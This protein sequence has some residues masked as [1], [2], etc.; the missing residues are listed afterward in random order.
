MLRRRRREGG[1]KVVS[2][3]KNLEMVTVNKTIYCRGDKIEL[4]TSVA[5]FFPLSKH[6]VKTKRGK[7]EKLGILHLS[8]N[9]LSRTYS[10]ISVPRIK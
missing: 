1:R 5:Q 9:T 2:S 7:K 3:D 10:D 6:K 8:H 4:V